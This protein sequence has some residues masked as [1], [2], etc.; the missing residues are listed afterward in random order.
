MRNALSIFRIRS[1]R[2]KLLGIVVFSF[3]AFSA[4]ISYNQTRETLTD[5]K[6]NLYASALSFAQLS[7]SSF[8]NLYLN[9]YDS[10]YHTFNNQT[11]EILNLNH[12]VF[13][14][15]IIDPKGSILYNSANINPNDFSPP[16]KTSSTIVDNNVLQAISTSQSL[17]LENKNKDIDKVLLPFTDPF[18]LKPFSIMYTISY[19]RADILS[20]KTL[21]S[22]ILTSLFSTLVVILLISLVLNVTVLAPLSKVIQG[23]KKITAGQLDYLIKVKSKDE[24]GDL[25]E[26]VNFM[27]SALRKDIEDLKSLDKLKD[28]FIIIAS[29]NLRTPLTSIKGY[30]DFLINDLTSIEMKDKEYLAKA[31]QATKKLEGLTEELINIVN[32]KSGQN[33]F[34]KLPIEVE[35][36]IKNSL[37]NFGSLIEEKKLKILTSVGTLPKVFVDQRSIESV[38]NNILDNA[39]KFSNPTGRVEINA[40]FDNGQVVISVRDYGKGMSE[41]QV[42]NLFQKFHRGEDVLTYNYEGEGLGLYLNYLIIQAHGGRIWAVSKPTAGSTFSFTLPIATK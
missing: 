19:D 25:S 18:G 7:V 5:T 33:P 21:R 10:G 2:F 20:Q 13:Q 27:A 11:Q 41:E 30:L 35:E 26:A 22:I 4:Y 12:D 40:F 37:D 23:A 3:L 29:H 6:K 16:I 1:I 17:Y 15:E 28:E 9:Y 34:N 24:I 38:L 32:I 8:G 39:I 14:V 42:D 36:I 31:N